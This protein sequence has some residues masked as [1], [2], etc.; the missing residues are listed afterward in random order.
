M[1]ANNSAKISFELSKVKDEIILELINFGCEIIEPSGVYF[2]YLEEYELEVKY[3]DMSFIIDLMNMPDD[4]SKYPECMILSDYLKNKKYL[5]KNIDR[6]ELKY[7]CYFISYTDF[8][9]ILF[10][11]K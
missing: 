2:E 8:M 4:K 9:E 7:D 11:T 6:F 5:Y 3:M 1:I 10:D